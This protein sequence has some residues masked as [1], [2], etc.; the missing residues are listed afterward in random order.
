MPL[1]LFLAF[2]AATAGANYRTIQ[3]DA[4]RVTGKIRSFQGVVDGPLPL[5]PRDATLTKQFKDLRIDFIRAHDLFGPVDIDARWPD[6]D[7]IA[8]AVGASA[9]KTVFPDWSADPERPES[10]NFEPTDRVI[11]AMVDSGAQVCYRLGRSWA[12]D[13]APPDNFD[14]YANVVKHV[15]MHYN[16]GWVHGFHGAVRYW[17]F[18]NEPDAEKAWNPQFIR[19]FWSGTPAQYYALYEKVARALKDVD[20]ALKVGGSAKAAADIAGPYREGFIQYCAAHKV[21]LD[22]FS[23]H[24]YFGPSLDPYDMVRLGKIM[25]QLL[26]ASGFKDAEIINT[27]WNMGQG[28]SARQPVS[29]SPMEAAAFV[30]SVL[31]YLQDS[32]L[33]HAC[34]Y[35]AEAGPRRL[36]TADGGYS[37]NAYVY[38]ATGSMLDTPDRLAATGGDTFGFAVLAGRSSDNRQV[39]VLIS[40]YEI[41]AQDRQPRMGRLRLPRQNGI[42]YSN[43]RGYA[44]QIANLPWGDA[45]Y[46]VKRYRLSETDNLSVRNLPA[47][48]GS[49]FELNSELAPPGFELIVLDRQ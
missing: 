19:P 22:F 41:P 35:R 45:A 8:T 15:A 23:W 20:P 42:S 36:F 38:R 17:E 4:S 26:D 6:P 37:K 32:L 1:I 29:H 31:I 49:R 11:K 24:H 34:Y 7:R 47:G 33:Q 25:R 28:L 12:A 16:A 40:N 13:A 48:R 10:Y 27:E 3:V 9:A 5:V 44:L 30:G 14:K 21:P 46:S 2:L 18:W 43:N 39:R